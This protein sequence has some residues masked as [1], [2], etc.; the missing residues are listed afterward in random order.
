MPVIDRDELVRRLNNFR[1]LYRA[2]DDKLARDAL[3][4]QIADLE[5]QIDRLDRVATRA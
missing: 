2:T 4:R 3:L 5:A 1:A